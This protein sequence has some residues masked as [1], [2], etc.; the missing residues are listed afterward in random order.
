MS[1]N[2]NN[3]VESL[4]GLLSNKIACEKMRLNPNLLQKDDFI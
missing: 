1:F 4:D 3:A 2:R